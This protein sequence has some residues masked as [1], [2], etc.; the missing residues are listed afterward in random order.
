M[1]WNRFTIPS[2]FSLLEKF[3]PLSIRSKRCS[4]PG[5]HV[6]LMLV[7]RELGTDRLR[8]FRFRHVTAMGRRASVVVRLDF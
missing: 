1:Q 2:R 3:V 7:F 6:Q 4:L 8:K 5:H